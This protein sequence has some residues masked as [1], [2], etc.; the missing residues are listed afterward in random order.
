MAQAL[1]N[2]NSYSNIHFEYNLAKDTFMYRTLKS[3]LNVQVELT[4]RCNHVCRH[5]Y[6]FF[7]H[8]NLPLRTIS[9]EQ[10]D[11]LVEELKRLQVVRVVITGG[12][13]LIVPET[14]LYSSRCCLEAGMS[15]SLNTNMTRFTR[16]IGDDL[17]KIGVSTIMT[18]LLAD[19]SEIHDRITQVPGSWQQ[20]ASNI[21]L[22]ISM[23]FRVLVNMV[24]TK[25]NIA[26]V[27]QTGDLVGGWK[28]AKFGATRACAPGPIAAGFWKNLVSVEEVRE[29][30]RILYELKEKWGYEVDV[31][32][33]YPWCVMEDLDKYRYLAR[34]K[35]TAGVTSAS[36]GADGQLRP[37]G[38]S[39]MKYGNVFQEGLTA[40][41]SRMEDWRRQQYSQVCNS[42]RFF[43]SCSGGCPVEAANS[44]NGKDHHCTSESDIVKMPKRIAAANIGDQQRFI[45]RSPLILRKESFGGIVA[46]AYAGLV[47]VDEQAFDTISSLARGECEIGLADIKRFG[48]TSDEAQ[49]LLGRLQKEKLITERQ[50]DE[51]VI[52]Q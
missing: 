31:F 11:I 9:K 32:E 35:C 18:S 14:A 40:P 45:F 23:G 5:C 3:P 4:E 52:H 51:S 30:L 47:Y 26:R 20:A 44:L 41:W 17:L 49:A 43:G 1:T 15:V 46:S 48:A 22:A 39:S 37:C 27:R 6:N 42:C 13:P 16:E 24:L 19:T 29:S 8:G 34:R 36:I 7:R 10:V 12:E 21:Q 25:W 50:Y 33:H 28:V 38:H 2:Q